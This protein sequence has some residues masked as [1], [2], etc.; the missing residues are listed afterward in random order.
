[1]RTGNHLDYLIYPLLVLG[2]LGHHAVLYYGLGI[3]ADL[4]VGGVGFLSVALVHIF[5]RLRPY[6]EDWNRDRGDFKSDAFLFPL[7]AALVRAGFITLFTRWPLPAV[8]DL[9]ASFSEV[10]A[11]VQLPFWLIAAEFGY[12]WYH[13]L[14]HKSALFWELHA[15]HH[16]AERVYWANSARFHS[17]DMVLGL[18][19]YLLP[20]YVFGASIEVIAWFLTFNSITGLL[21]HANIRFTAG[22]LNHFFNTAELHRWHHSADPQVSARNLGKVLSVWDQV[23]GTFHY[24]P[25]DPID[26]IGVL[27]S[28]PVPQGYLPQ[29]VYPF[30]RMFQ[31]SKRNPK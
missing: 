16:G 25:G 20:L 30:R 29:Q 13:R 17:L 6:R 4:V 26:E 19:I 7:L 2:I 8:V 28:D 22:R 10:P 5:E 12:Y 15:V 1:M 3:S 24:K 9:G 21:E 31:S 11:W 27:D 18:V 14:C 23:F